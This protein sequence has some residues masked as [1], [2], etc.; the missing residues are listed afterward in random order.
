VLGLLA[1]CA[2]PELAVDVSQHPGGFGRHATYRWQRPAVESVPGRPGS[3]ALRTD[4]AV[5][6]A[7]QQRLSE[8]G[9]RGPEAGAAD[10]VLAYDIRLRTKTTDSFTEFLDYKRSGG[11]KD[12]GQAYI[13]GFEEATLTLQA[14]DGADDRVV[15]HGEVTGVADPTRSGKK[16]PQAVDALLARFP[17]GG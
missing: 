13:D 1:A 3:L 6:R 17:D 10:V 14:V 4:W 7:V 9:W 5:R 11:A 15:W 12:F 16:I 2:G 8:K